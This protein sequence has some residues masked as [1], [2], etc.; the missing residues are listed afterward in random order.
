MMKASDMALIKAVGR[1]LKEALDGLSKRIDTIE[2]SQGVKAAVG[3]APDPRIDELERRLK[4]I[5]DRGTL[6]YKGVWAEGQ[7]YSKGECVTQDGSIWICKG[8]HVRSKP[9]TDPTLWQLAV[10]RGKDGRDGTNA[11]AR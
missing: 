5:E 10:K 8:Y 9:G 6:E 11:G 7:G 1:V 3:S 4:T 2:Q